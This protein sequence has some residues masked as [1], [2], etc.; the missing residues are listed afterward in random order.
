MLKE[1]LEVSIFAKEYAQKQSA[2]VIKTNSETSTFAD[3]TAIISSHLRPISRHLPEQLP[4]QKS[5]HK[6]E[7]KSK[8]TVSYSNRFFTLT[9]LL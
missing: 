7:D 5:G 6:M 1:K 4:L 2:I 3:R 9:L 8:R